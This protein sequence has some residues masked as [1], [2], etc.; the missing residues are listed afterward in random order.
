[1]DGFTG[2]DY[3]VATVSKSQI[4]TIGITIPKLKSSG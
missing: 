4:I 2:N 3:R 1:M